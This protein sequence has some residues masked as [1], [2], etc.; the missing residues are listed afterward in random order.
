MTIKRKAR[1]MN[2]QIINNQDL[3]ENI[4]LV[5]VAE[6]TVNSVRVKAFSPLIRG[7]DPAGNLIKGGNRSLINPIRARKR[8]NRISLY[9]RIYIITNINPIYIEF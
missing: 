3:N 5:I 4:S 1:D 2:I 6:F 9:R 7:S 8:R